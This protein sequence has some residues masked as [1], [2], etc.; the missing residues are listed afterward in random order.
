[1]KILVVD[2]ESAIRDLLVTVL[3]DEGYQAIAAGG[4]REALERAPV[5]RPDLVLIDLMMPGMDGRQLVRRLRE[6]PGLDVVPMVMMSAA[7]RV[8]T[9]QEGVVDFLPKPFDLD[10]LLG[11][12]QRATGQRLS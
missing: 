12:I 3:E 8:M 1:M 10:Q 4:G 7:V 6:L 5:E 2:D 11:T 9:E